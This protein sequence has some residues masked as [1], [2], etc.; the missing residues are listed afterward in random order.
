MKEQDIS[1]PTIGQTGSSTRQE[2]MAWIFMLTKP[3]RSMYATDSAAMLCKAEQLLAKAKERQEAI[4]A[5]RRIK[6]GCLFKKP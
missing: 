3:I 6:H 4:N 5:D 1:G 2:L